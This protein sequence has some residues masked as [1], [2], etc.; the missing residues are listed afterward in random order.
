MRFQDSIPLRNA[1]SIFLAPLA[2]FTYVPLKTIMAFQGE[3]RKKF[4][5][6]QQLHHGHNKASLYIHKEERESCTKFILLLSFHNLSRNIFYDFFDV[7]FNFVRPT[8]FNFIY[9]LL[10]VF[11]FAINVCF[12]CNTVLFF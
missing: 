5:L 6:R 9:F 7:C 11:L 4:H 2:L 12:V 8:W 3:R 10:R 1:S